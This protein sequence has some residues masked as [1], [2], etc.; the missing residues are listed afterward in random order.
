[1]IA[2]FDNIYFMFVQSKHLV[3]VKK[4]TEFDS[5]YKIEAIG[6]DGLSKDTKK[7]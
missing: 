1:M 3:N 6:F 4:T 7:K 2:W 5:I